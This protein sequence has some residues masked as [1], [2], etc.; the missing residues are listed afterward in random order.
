MTGLG[1]IDSTILLIAAIISVVAI[2]VLSI[3][4]VKVRKRPTTVGPIT[5]ILLILGLIFVVFLVYRGSE[6]ESADWAQILLT[7]GLVLITAVYAWSASKQADASVKMAE[8]TKEQRYAALKPIIDINRSDMYYETHKEYDE[9]RTMIQK[10]EL[11]RSLMCKL[12]SIGPGPA[13]DVHSFIEDPYG[14]YKRRDHGTIVTGQDYYEQ[15]SLFLER[16]DDRGFLVVY[17]KDVYGQPFKSSREVK[18]NK[19]GTGLDIDPLEIC[20]LPKEEQRQ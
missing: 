2:L 14:V 18:I 17:Y 5:I 19:E 9:V 1:G 6:L 4:Q 13:I 3:I 7:I 16:K 20:E 12:V 15:V 8:E 11:P 10:H